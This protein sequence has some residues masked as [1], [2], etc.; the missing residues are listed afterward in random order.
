MAPGS[1][2]AVRVSAAKKPSSALPEASSIGTGG[3]LTSMAG[4]AAPADLDAMGPRALF[5]QRDFFRLGQLRTLFGL[6][7]QLGLALLRDR[8]RDGADE[9]GSR[10]GRWIQETHRGETRHQLGD[11]SE[12][13]QAEHREHGSR[14]QGAARLA[15]HGTPNGD[16]VAMSAGRSHEVQFA[17][18][19]S[20][21]CRHKARSMAASLSLA[22]PLATFDLSAFL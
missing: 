5:G 3:S 11:A 1:F 16:A 7:L 12:R 2:F 20:P 4:N 21:S 15:Q 10:I 6:Q 18:D 14:Q 9:R 13:G 17:Q 19:M 22:L 8:G